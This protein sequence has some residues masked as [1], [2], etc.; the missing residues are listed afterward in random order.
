MGLGASSEPPERSLPV[1]TLMKHKKF[2]VLHECRDSYRSF[3]RL[4]ILLLLLLLLLLLQA[5]LEKAPRS[6]K[7][8]SGSKRNRLSRSDPQPRKNRTSNSQLLQCRSSKMHNA[9]AIFDGRSTRLGIDSQG[10]P[11]VLFSSSCSCG[12]CSSL[13]AGR[14]SKNALCS[15]DKLRGPQE[16]CAFHSQP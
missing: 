14:E 3:R 12:A 7:P 2:L 8:K 5:L 1:P 10:P 16:G 9:G 11:G 15:A 6:S 13:C 4:A